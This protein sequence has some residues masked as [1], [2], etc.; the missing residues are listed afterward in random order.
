MLLEGVSPTTVRDVIFFDENGYMW[1]NG[2]I[3]DHGT[4]M[5][6]RE[7][8]KIALDSPVQTLIHEQ[9]KYRAFVSAANKAET[10]DDLVFFKSA[11]WNEQYRQDLLEQL[12]RYGDTRQLENE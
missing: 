3:A 7:S 2:K 6:L 1:I 4:A 5:A 12:A 9:I 10:T 11:V 8:A